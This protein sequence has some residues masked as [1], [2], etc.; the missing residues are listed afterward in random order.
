MKAALARTG[1]APEQIQYV[2]M[3]HER[4]ITGL[5]LQGRT[6]YRKQ[7]RL[8][9]RQAHWPIWYHH[10]NSPYKGFGRDFPQQ[11]RDVLCYPYL[12]DR[13]PMNDV[14]PNRRNR[15]QG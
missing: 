3:G 15:S 10:L 13:I 8:D 1:G 4:R 7:V 6:F 12:V 9:N 14:T 2:I 5:R 11:G